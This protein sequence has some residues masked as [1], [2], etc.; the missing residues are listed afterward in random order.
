MPTRVIGLSTAVKSCGLIG[1][2]TWPE[3]EE[4]PI[5][6]PHPVIL[7]DS[8]PITNMLGMSTGGL[9]SRSYKGSITQGN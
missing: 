9:N 2:R 3:T 4:L 5:Y 1:V 6:Y 8:F 7:P